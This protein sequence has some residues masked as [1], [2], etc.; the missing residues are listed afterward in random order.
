MLL[1]LGGMI[2]VIHAAVLNVAEMNRLIAQDTA[3][4]V[5]ALQGMNVTAAR[6]R[7]LLRESLSPSA[8]LPA[9][10][11]QIAAQRADFAENH[12]IWL[13][14]PIDPGESDL[15]D[16]AKVRVEQVDEVLRRVLATTMTTSPTTRDA[17]RE[18]LDL[19]L[20]MLDD[21]IMRAT[22][23]NADL[24][25][26][27]SVVAARVGRR[28]LPAAIATEATS[29]VLAAFA[30]FAAHRAQRIE[31]ELV[32]HRVLQK[33]NAELEAFAGRVAHDVLSPLTAVGLALGAAQ[34]R[35]MSPGDERIRGML[36]RAVSSLQRVRGVVS[37]LLSF[38]RAAATPLPGAATAVAPLLQSL[39]HD[40]EPVAAAEG[41]ELRLDDAPPTRVRCSE[42]ILS[43]IVTNLVQNA[44]R[45]T[46]KA[47]HRVDVRAVDEG[48]DVRFEVEDTGAGVAPE[49]RERIFEPYVRATDQGTGLGLGLATVKRL[50]ES[51][52]G[53]V[54]VRSP[55]AQGH[56]ALFWVTLPA[57]A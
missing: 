54:G 9:L 23:L 30:L 45:H 46:D 17:L 51:H 19:K 3:P 28:L 21:V 31:A 1:G 47:E 40:L 35:L 25:H 37:D 26:R 39:V 49:D 38:A 33:K 12:E 43:S 50:A 8:N 55:C 52:G 44:I 18:E 5:V 11:A 42:G 29:L 48:T 53:H 32:E 15:M 56:G 7:T 10:R 14:L 27:A 6:L 24:A 2:G 34:T 4:G 41:V 20:N 16:E 13:S 57:A 22:R 36:G